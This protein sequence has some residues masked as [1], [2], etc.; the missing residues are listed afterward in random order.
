MTDPNPSLRDRELE[1]LAGRT[2]GGKY[3][4]TRLL[5]RGGMGAVYEAEHV[6]IGKKVALKFVDREFAKDDLVIGRFAREA[7]AASS[8]ESAHIVTVFDAGVDEGRP[9]LVMELLRGE[10]LGTRLRRL[11]KL[12]MRESFHIVAQVLRGLARAHSVGIVHRDLKPDNVFL[13]QSEGDP[14]FAKIV[15]FGVSK[16]Q[17]AQGGTAPLALTGKGTVL[18]TPLYMS[19]EQAQVSPD[20]DGRADL[21]S[22]G[23]IL[24]ECLAGRPPHT[25]ASYEQIIL[26][27]CM[28]DA[29]D[30]SAIDPQIPESASAFVARALARD[31]ANRHQS[32]AQML[33]ALHEIA[34]EE[35]ARVPLDSSLAAT[36]VSAVD[37]PVAG[38]PTD[39]SWS[40]GSP[41]SPIVPLPTVRRTVASR[42]AVP[43]TAL[44]ATLAG[45]FVTLWIVMSLQKRTTNPAP[46]AHAA[47]STA[48]L[49]PASSESVAAR[50]KPPEPPEVPSA[51][52]APAQPALPRSRTRAPASSGHPPPRGASAG[53]ATTTPTAA[54]TPL[55]TP[56][57]ALDISRE[58]PD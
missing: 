57:P 27:I 28:T 11:S 2:V 44:G 18:G 51:Q 26:A 46:P 47:K 49:A 56:K 29:P 41:G 20:L 52:P 6:G 42:L 10:D 54:P 33:S 7:R 50:P 21:Y 58:L 19:P 39:V 8:I 9:Y 12:S 22:V 24:F 53:A 36:R 5:G 23:A 15:D 31:R 3:A 13:V 43:L 14:L 34:P 32:A 48:S 45:V 35:K 25:G 40:R 55:G 17:R 37:A 1:D 16:I 38:P 30:L 4:V